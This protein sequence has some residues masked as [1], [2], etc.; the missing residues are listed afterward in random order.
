MAGPGYE[1]S[2]QGGSDEVRSIELSDS[3]TFG[4]FLGSLNCGVSY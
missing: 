1:P 3:L 2:Q 4:H